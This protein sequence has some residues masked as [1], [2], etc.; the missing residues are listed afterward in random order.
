MLAVASKSRQRKP[1]FLPS[2][3]Q[4]I[5][6]THYTQFISTCL[7]CRLTKISVI[8]VSERCRL[9]PLAGIHRCMRSYDCTSPKRQLGSVVSTQW[10]NMATAYSCRLETVRSILQ[11]SSN[12]VSWRSNDED[13]DSAMRCLQA[14][15]PAYNDNNRQLQPRVLTVTAQCIATISGTPHAASGHNEMTLITSYLADSASIELPPGQCASID[16]V[17]CIAA[18]AAAVSQLQH[19]IFSPTHPQQGRRKQIF[20]G[21]TP[22]SMMYNKSICLFVGAN[23]NLFISPSPKTTTKAR[24][25]QCFLLSINK[26]D[27]IIRSI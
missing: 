8:A 6:V 12:C 24:F 2:V 22:V 15:P 14:Q 21:G 10:C 9:Q 17:P 19:R 27:V 7:Q 18:A 26:N 20:V 16:A 4:V 23:I 25:N 11:L 1:T 5:H 3:H 13:T